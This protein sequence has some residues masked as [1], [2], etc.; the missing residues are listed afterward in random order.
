MKKT[1]WK[2]GSNFNCFMK[3]YLVGAGPG[4]PELI[5]LK[6]KRIL[7]EANIVFYDQLV[8][9]KILSF[10]NSSVELYSVGKERSKHS[11]PQDEIH[12]LLLTASKKFKTVVR[13][14][15]GD[16]S[17]FGRVGEEYFF[18]LKNGIDVEIIPGI[19]TASGSSA[20][21]GMPL[22]HRDFSSEVIF[23][24]GHSKNGV[25]VSKLKNLRLK[26]KTL[27][28]YMGIFSS[29]EIEKTLLET[30]ENFE[31]KAMVIE[32]ATLESERV[33]TCNLNELNKTII[34]KEIKSPSLIIIGDIVKFYLEK[35]KLK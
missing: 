13:L 29:K 2:R 17:I 16:P 20:S 4:D 7:E 31:M 12:E 1:F 5:T 32:N 11:V 34:E 24:T 6:A 26:D 35:E 15:G 22:T 28:V 10:C 25:E 30:E 19:T 8:S 21:I 27:V 18:L 33:V 9:S 14:K 3:V 23:I